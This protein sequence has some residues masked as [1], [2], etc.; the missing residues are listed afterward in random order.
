MD[1]NC[2]RD[3]FCCKSAL[4]WIKRNSALDYSFI[5]CVALSLHKSVGLTEVHPV[6]SVLLQQEKKL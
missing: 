6:V 5:I 3:R 4:R 1:I 2:L